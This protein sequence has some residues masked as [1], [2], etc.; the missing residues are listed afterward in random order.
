MSHYARTVESFYATALEGE[1]ANGRVKVPVDTAIKCVTLIAGGGYV[2]KAEIA[3]AWL[4]L[5]CFED[6]PALTDKGRAFREAQGWPTL[7]PGRPAA[8]SGP[9][10]ARIVVEVTNEQKAWCRKRAANRDEKLAEYVRR[11]LLEEG[12]PR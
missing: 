7:T 3:G 5:R 1:N 2:F 12:M 6:L 11:L 4:N 9:L 8:A 10:D